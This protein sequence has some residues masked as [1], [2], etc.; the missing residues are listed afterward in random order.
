MK[1]YHKKESQ[2]SLGLKMTQCNPDKPSIDCLVEATRDFLI[3]IDKYKSLKS[4][5]QREW[6]VSGE[7]HGVWLY[8]CGPI[9]GGGRVL[10]TNTTQ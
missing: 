1:I 10:Q 3:T 8:G 9:S 7:C 2:S 4:Q 5:S 6:L